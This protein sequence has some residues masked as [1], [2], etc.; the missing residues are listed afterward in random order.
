MGTCISTKNTMKVSDMNQNHTNSVRCVTIEVDQ[1]M[2]TPKDDSSEDGSVEVT[3]LN[4]ISIY[5]SPDRSRTTDRNYITPSPRSLDRE[6]RSS[7]HQNVANVVKINVH[8]DRSED[9]DDDNDEYPNYFD[10][11]NFLWI[12]ATLASHMGVP[13]NTKVVMDDNVTNMNDNVAKPRDRIYANDD[14]LFMSVETSR[15]SSYL[16]HIQIS[17]PSM[18]QKQPPGFVTNLNTNIVVEN[19]N[20]KVINKTILEDYHDQDFTINN[21][22]H[23]DDWMSLSR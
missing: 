22:H 5:K 1:K 6:D 12:P 11:D 21:L 4:R 2:N 3:D 9:S 19:L 14:D 20:N 10:D 23:T 15:R 16:T 18:K 13:R 8:T 17:P 7:G